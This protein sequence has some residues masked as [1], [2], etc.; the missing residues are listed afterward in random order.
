MATEQQQIPAQQVQ[1]AA[2]GNN[3]L[4]TTVQLVQRYWVRVT[5]TMNEENG[6]PRVASKLPY[7]LVAQDG[8]LWTVLSTGVIASTGRASF[9][10]PGAGRYRAYVKE[11]TRTF[12]AGTA[13]EIPYHQ[14]PTG[15]DSTREVQPWFEM[16]I[17]ATG[18]PQVFQVRQALPNTLG[19]A[20]NL[21]PAASTAPHTLTQA[22]T[23]AATPLDLGNYRITNQLWSDVSRCYG[24]S[25]AAVTSSTSRAALELIYGEQLTVFAQHGRRLQLDGKTIEFEAGATAGGRQTLGFADDTHMTA[26]ECLRKAYPNVFDW[27]WQSMAT[28]RLSNAI[29]SSTWRPHQGSTLH[30]YS[31]A[32]DL[33]NLTGLVDISPTETASISIHLHVQEDD[34]NPTHNG[35]TNDPTVIR[36]RLLSKAFHRYLAEE[37][38]AGRLGWLGG[39][40]P[41]TRS[42]VG[43][44]GNT[45]FIATD[46]GHTHH[47]HVTVGIDQA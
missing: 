14:L 40:W 8:N 45:Q 10:I 44:S 13:F 20:A 35:P 37:R 38:A 39:P 1:S 7:I 47:V 21:Y 15:Q 16:E 3:I 4:Q 43:L 42:Q 26:S 17:T 18:N 32:L 9:G 11:P 31:L 25:H 46:S 24:I 2:N 27:W 19:R 36:K 33:K 28:L 34:A 30:R 6:Q 5:V 23:S 22:H 41:L 12:Q 29:V